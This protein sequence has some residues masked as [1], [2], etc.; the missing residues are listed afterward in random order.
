MTSSRSSERVWLSQLMANLESCGLNRVL[1]FCGMGVCQQILSRYS[2]CSHA[3]QHML[4]F[5]LAMLAS[6]ALVTIEQLIL[7]LTKYSDSCQLVWP[8]LVIAGSDDR[9]VR[10]IFGFAQFSILYLPL[11]YCNWYW[12]DEK[13]L[14]EKVKE[15]NRKQ[16]FSLTFAQENWIFDLL[17]LATQFLVCIIFHIFTILFVQ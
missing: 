5:G 9:T 12:Q 10:W 6:L 4:K 2:I 13:L 8:Y 14:V 15:A 17:T 3:E 1:P 7:S 16:W 11:C